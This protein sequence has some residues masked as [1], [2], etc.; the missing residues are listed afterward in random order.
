MLKCTLNSWNMIGQELD[1][2]PDYIFFVN[3]YLS[4]RLVHTQC[5]LRSADNQNLSVN[6][7]VV[8]CFVGESCPWATEVVVQSKL[9][10]YKSRP[11]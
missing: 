5:S 1:F 4:V 10:I 9:M 7:S 2:M 11:S 3:A 6:L 8:L